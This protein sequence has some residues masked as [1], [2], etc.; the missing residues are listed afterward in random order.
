MADKEFRG[1]W[2]VTLHVGL[3]IK[4]LPVILHDS[5]FINDIAPSTLAFSKTSTIHAMG[6]Y[7][8]LV[9]ELSKEI[10]I[11]LAVITQCWHEKQKCVGDAFIFIGINLHFEFLKVDAF[12]HMV[13]MFGRS[14]NWKCLSH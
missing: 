1:V 13:N 12:D 2:M 4:E 10:P 5:V 6:S 9:S 7:S 11:I 3:G 8:V 14:V